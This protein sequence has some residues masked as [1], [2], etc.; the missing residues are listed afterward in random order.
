MQKLYIGVDP[1]ID[2]SG[3]CLYYSKTNFELLNLKFFELFD[4]LYFL[5]DCEN[6][7]IEV[8]IEAGWLNKSNWHKVTNG[9]A[10]INANIGLRTGANHEVG[11]KIVEM[12]QYLGLKHHLI[13][14]TKSKVNAE[15]FKAITKY[16]GRTNSEMRDSCLLVYGR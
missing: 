10:A 6:L 1:D 8:V 3:V 11:R 4:K 16:Q 14:P 2:K 12:C 5:K 15:T 9:S 13:K 7:D